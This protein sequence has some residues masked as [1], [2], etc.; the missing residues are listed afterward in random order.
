MVIH[1]CHSRVQ[2]TEA[3]LVN[4]RPVWSMQDDLMSETKSKQR[5]WEKVRYKQMCLKNKLWLGVPLLCI[6]EIC[7][8]SK[9]KMDV[10]A[11]RV[12]LLKQC[13][14]FRFAFKPF[15]CCPERDCKVNPFC[16]EVPAGQPGDPGSPGEPGPPGRKV[17]RTTPCELFVPQRSEHGH[18]P[19]RVH[20]AS[21]SAAWP[22]FLCKGENGVN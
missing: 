22:Q 3:R 8:F 4:W 20:T 12:L 11:L 16:L 9:M 17:S 18:T 1:S 7:P 14:N 2:K 21:S 6:L 10:F 5:H 13:Q 19:L 15:T